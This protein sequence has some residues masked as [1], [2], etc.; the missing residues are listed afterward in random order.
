MRESEAQAIDAI[1]AEVHAHQSS[2]KGRVEAEI[3]KVRVGASNLL[4][5]RMAN[6]TADEVLDAEVQLWAAM[7]VMRC[8]L[9]DVRAANDK[10]GYE[11]TLQAAE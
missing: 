4:K 2:P 9:E 3:D 11:P 7:S 5:L 8:L 1:I 6:D 10:R